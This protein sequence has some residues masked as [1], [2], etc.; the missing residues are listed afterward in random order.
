MSENTMHI[1]DYNVSIETNVLQA[2]KRNEIYKIYFF[3]KVKRLKNKKVHQIFSHF[4]QN[5]QKMFSSVFY[6]VSFKNHN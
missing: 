2:E 4:C 5:A 3:K 1:N 6:K